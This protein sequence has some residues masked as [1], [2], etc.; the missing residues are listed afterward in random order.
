MIAYDV[1]L[2][3]THTNSKS[4]LLQVLQYKYLNLNI[5]K[6]VQTIDC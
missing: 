3:D 2:N 4:D 6:Y 5:D 1:T